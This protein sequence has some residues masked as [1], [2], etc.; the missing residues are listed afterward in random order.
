MSSSMP[1]E[2]EAE[3]IKARF[4]KDG[5]VR[6]E[7]FFGAAMMQRL[8]RAIMAHYGEA[9]GDWHED[10][11][12]SLSQTDVVPW[13]PQRDAGP[14]PVFA[15]IASDAR[16]TAITEALLGPGWS[17]LDAMAMFSRQGSPGQAWHQDCPPE[18]AQRYNLNRLIYAA[19]ISPEIG[20]GV[21]VMPGSHRMGTL[22]AGG[23]HEDL[24]GQ[25]ELRPAAGDL[26]LLHGHCWH[27]VLPVH[28][29]HRHSINYR[30]AV[31]GTPL[32]VTDICV[33]RNMRYRFST[34][35]VVENRV[36]S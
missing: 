23:P 20:G 36:T 6:I 25:V 31:R 9:P 4:D 22:P 8:D 5:F 10:S 13:F 3:A 11:F 16:L 30:A 21:I 24:S 32:D 35:E 26:I 2:D 15:E 14:D 34:C 7:G 12:I 18:N 1:A 27:R 19:P 28:G 33:Y 29:G 17:S